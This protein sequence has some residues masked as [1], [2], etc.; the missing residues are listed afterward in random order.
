MLVYRIAKPRLPGREPCLNLIAT[1]AV[2]TRAATRAELKKALAWRLTAVSGGADNTRLSSGPLSHMLNIW[3][4]SA[5][6]RKTWIATRLT[7]PTLFGE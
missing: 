2:L 7:A 6:I 3:A 1:D 4:Q 5:T